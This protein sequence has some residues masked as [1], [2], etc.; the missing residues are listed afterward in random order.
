MADR[1][2]HAPEVDFRGAGSRADENLKLAL[3]IAQEAGDCT[4]RGT[5]GAS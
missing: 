4:T 5:G 3:S 1:K 2:G